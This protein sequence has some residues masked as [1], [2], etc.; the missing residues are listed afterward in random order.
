MFTF[1][2]GQV[3]FCDKTGEKS[4]QLLP[5]LVTGIKKVFVFLNL[6]SFIRVLLTFHLSM[7]A[8]IV[9]KMI[10]CSLLS[11]LSHDT[12]TSDCNVWFSRTT[13]VTLIVKRQNI[14]MAFTGSVRNIDTYATS[15]RCHRD[16]TCRR[17]KSSIPFS[18]VDGGT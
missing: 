2:S 5:A 3:L 4:R 16:I 1:L 6:T 17:K 11:L 8:Y 15:L 18:F 13:I 9:A 7:L 14:L 10:Q 12:M